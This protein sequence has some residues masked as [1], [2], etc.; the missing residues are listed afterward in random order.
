M[1]TS[2]SQLLCGVGGG[3]LCKVSDSTV[4]LLL[5]YCSG[6]GCS[7]PINANPGLKVNRS[8]NFS[9][10]KNVFHCSCFV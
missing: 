2:A 8:N 5:C 4:M 10:I 6:P 1:L 9:C 3:G 7:K